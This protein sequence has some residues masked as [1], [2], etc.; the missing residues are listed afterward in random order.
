M[1][2][3]SH[4]EFDDHERVVFHRDA[5]S[6]LDCIVAI[7]STRLGPGLG[8]CRVFPYASD[9]DALTDVLRLS[10]GMTYKAALAGLRQG[11]GKAVILA[12]P[13]TGKTP[14]MMRAMGRLVQSLNGAYVI[15]E[16][17]GTHLAD[18]QQVMLETT[19][20]GGDSPLS[21]LA[22]PAYR[23][24]SA[25]TAY[26]VFIGIRTAVQHRMSR[27]DL[28][29]LRVAIQGV[30]KVGAVLAQ[31]LHEAGA[32]LWVSDSYA[33]AVRACVQSCGATAV[34]PQ[35]IFDLDVDVF[36]P[37]AL[38]AILDEASIPKLRACVIGGAANNQL[39]EVRHGEMLRQRGILYAPDYVI[40]A[41]GIINISYEG[42]GYSWAASEVHVRRIGD[43]LDQI[44]RRSDA[45]QRPTG[46][47]AD[48][49]AEAIFRLPP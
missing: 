41:G 32:Q 43:T 21:P 44:F 19:Y 42:P 6:G 40:N 14:A 8:G 2:V 28:A 34:A 46:E 26:G 12:D 35:D 45:D 17:S 24:T 30:G 36:A 7:H 22:D 11:G 48:R 3:F 10:R 38:G 18:M 5:R 4:P 31:H 47:I 27:S 15:A 37:C 1:P 16:D 39:A 13:H 25:A 9:A 23:D 29:G 49:M 20:L 33:P